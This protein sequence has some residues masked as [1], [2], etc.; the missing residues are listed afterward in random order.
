MDPASS[1]DLLHCAVLIARHAYPAAD[2]DQI[3]AAVADLGARAA[4]LAAA[5]SSNSS[6]SSSSRARAL[7]AAVSHVLY[8][9]EGFQGAVD[10]YYS[11]DSQCINKLLETK[12]GEQQQQQLQSR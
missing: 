9:V 5:T 11:P 10:D 4:A 7:A 12:Q 3:R 8:E 2:L 6:S 1:I